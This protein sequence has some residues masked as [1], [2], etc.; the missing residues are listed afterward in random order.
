[1]MRER[2]FDSWRQDFLDLWLK[3][4]AADPPQEFNKKRKLPESKE[5]GYVWHRQFGFVHVLVDNI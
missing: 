4:G 3:P 1:M 5:T 2:G